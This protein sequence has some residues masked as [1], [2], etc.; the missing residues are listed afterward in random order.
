MLSPEAFGELLNVMMR[1]RFDRFLP[2]KERL[3]ALAMIARLASWMNPWCQYQ[4]C[5]DPTDDK[6]LSLAVC[7]AASMIITRDNDLLDMG[8]FN[9]IGIVS[10]QSFVEASRV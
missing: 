9:G 7:A 1:A 6:Y 8:S 10:P 3:D 4:A 2:M 5:R